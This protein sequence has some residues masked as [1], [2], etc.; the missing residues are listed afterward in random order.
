MRTYGSYTCV[1]RA[2]GK[3]VQ[4]WRVTCGENKVLKKL[5]L[6]HRAG[7]GDSRGFSCAANMCAKE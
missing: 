6:S 7:L 1:L 5:L 4:A 2:A 3:N